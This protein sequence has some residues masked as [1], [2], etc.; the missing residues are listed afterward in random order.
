MPEQKPSTARPR[1]APGAELRAKFTGSDQG[2]G[3]LG[4]PGVL[5]TM[6]RNR[7]IEYFDL[8]LTE[9]GLLYK[10]VEPGHT[11]DYMSEEEEARLPEW[12]RAPE[13]S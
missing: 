3:H 13:E 6:I 5:A 4:V 12:I 9:E 1:P 10:P 7:G 11:W 8:Y 2:S